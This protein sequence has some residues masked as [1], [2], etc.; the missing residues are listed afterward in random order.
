[1]CGIHAC[2]SRAGPQRPSQ[3]LQDRLYK[4]GPDHVGRAELQR[5]SYSDGDDSAWLSFT[6]TVLALRGG[7]I[8]Q[9]PFYDHVTESVLCWNGEAWKIKGEVLT[10]NDGQAVYDLLCRA[11]Q[12]TSSRSEA[13]AAVLEA[14]KSISG[15]FAFVYHDKAHSLVYFSRDRLGR[16]SLLYDY[17]DIPDV[18]QLASIAEPTGGSWQEV[19]ADAIYVLD[20]SGSVSSP[21]TILVEDSEISK[22][23]F[24]IF[25]SLW[26]TADTHD[27]T[28][29]CISL[30]N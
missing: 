27:D 30:C 11:S 22:S 7:H 10:G 20:L 18:L 21:N 6:S 12:S 25:K 4:R 8:T 29:S 14:V 24:P 9:Q 19:E 1:M 15:P 26:S 28:V 16:R 3:A 17:E 13:I 5:G 23:G 2:I